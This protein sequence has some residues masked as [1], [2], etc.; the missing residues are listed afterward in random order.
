[1]SSDGKYLAV[2]FFDGSIS[3]LDTKT[4]TILWTKKDYNHVIHDIE[5]LPEINQVV[6]TGA[7][8]YLYSQGADYIMVRNTETGQLIKKLEPKINDAYFSKIEVSDDGELMSSTSGFDIITWETKNFSLINRI[9]PAYYFDALEFS[10]VRDFKFIPNSHELLIC[11]DKLITSYNPK[12]ETFSFNFNNDMGAFTGIFNTI[13]E[14]GFFLFDRQQRRIDVY[15]LDRLNRTNFD[16]YFWMKLFNVYND[17]HDGLDF[18][19]PYLYGGNTVSFNPLDSTIGL[20]ANEKGLSFKGVKEKNYFIT[21]KMDTWEE[22]DVYGPFKWNEDEQKKYIDLLHINEKNNFMIM[23]GPIKGNAMNRTLYFLS[24]SKGKKIFEQEV[25]NSSE[26]YQISYNQEYLVLQNS[27]FSLKLISLKNFKEIFTENLHQYNVGSRFGFTSTNEFFFTKDEIRDSVSYSDVIIHDL[28]SNESD[29]ITSIPF[30]SPTCVTVKDSILVVG[31]NYDYSKRKWKDSVQFKMD[32]YGSNYFRDNNMVIYDLENDTIL[33]KIYA[34]RNFFSKCIVKN[35][36]VISQQF[37]ENIELH[38]INNSNDV[39]HYRFEYQDIFLGRDKYKASKKAIS[40]IGISYQNKVYPI[41]NFDLLYNQPHQLMTDLGFASKELVSAYES[42]YHKRIDRNTI[43]LSELM[44]SS[45]YELLPEI[46]L[47]NKHKIKPVLQSTK[48]NFDF[49]IYDSLYNRSRYQFF[50]NGV[51]YFSGSGKLL[52]HGKGKWNTVNETISLSQGENNI[53]VIATN[54][55]GF[56]SLPVNFKI[57][58]EAKKTELPDLYLITIGVSEYENKNYNL[59]YASKDANDIQNFFSKFDTTY[60]SDGTAY[61]TKRYNF[62]DDLIKNVH[63]YKI[64]DNDA[65]RSKILELKDVLKKSKVDDIVMLF[66]SGHGLLDS[67]NQYYF[68][69]HD[70]DFSNPGIRGL[71]FKDINSLFDGISCRKKLLFMDT[72][73]SGDLDK[74]DQN[75]NSKADTIS[76]PDIN[77]NL[78]KGARV[79]MMSEEERYN[80]FEIMK[81][82]FPE[83]NTTGTVIIS[84]SSGLGYAIENDVW[85]NGVFTYAILTGLAEYKADKNSDRKITV[86]ELRD[87]VI[88]EVEILTEGKQKPTSRQENVEFDFRVW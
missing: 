19:F 5:F 59:R 76:F 77:I 7:K 34:D 11:S 69:T 54:E 2:G 70:I 6:F 56:E 62:P 68:A 33:R 75:N 80:S 23:G 73:H 60:F 1:M 10:S 52:N 15:Q 50:I 35:N 84:A 45:I 63:R 47:V 36:L 83:F 55:K 79:L 46:R 51:P 39:Y 28:V 44:D 72:C 16:M 8:D 31:L 81:D 78:T 66:I 74:S 38:P 32:N 22:K 12:N 85:Q 42:A 49:Q 58:C 86:S 17:K 13:G 4:Y 88:E 57:Q 25:R 20:W 53:K 30:N 48:L 64:T 24:L 29:T 18:S 26:M 40:K 87:F 3:L 9:K 82:L 14:K 27:A 61:Y 71:N 21:F 41:H 43:P 37:W 67:D 65:T